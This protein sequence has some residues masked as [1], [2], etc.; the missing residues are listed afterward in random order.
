MAIFSIKKTGKADLTFVG[1]YHD[2]ASVETAA[3]AGAVRQ[4]GLSALGTST[5]L[6]SGQCIVRSPLVFHSFGSS[7]LRYW[8]CLS[9]IF[10]RRS[11]TDEMQQM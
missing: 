10:P 9:P 11:A 8:H 2:S 3:G 1:F 7:S 6:W 5:P 4:D